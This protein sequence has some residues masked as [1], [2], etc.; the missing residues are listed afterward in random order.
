MKIPNY[1]WFLIIPI[2]AGAIA[3]VVAA[4]YPT[5]T[6][7]WSALLCALLGAVVA[8]IAAVKQVQEPAPPVGTLS[9][10]DLAPDGTPQPKQRGFLGRWL[11]G[12]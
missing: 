9:A 5:A 1:V 4:F 12:K 11:V 10:V 2:F 6:V 7:F 8:A 3:P